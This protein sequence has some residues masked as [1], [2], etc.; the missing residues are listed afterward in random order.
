MLRS[1]RLNHR[2]D[3]AP[4]RARADE[5][6]VHVQRVAVF[7]ARAAGAQRPSG[8]IEVAR[9]GCAVEGNARYAAIERPEHRGVFRCVGRVQSVQGIANDRI[10]IERLRDTAPDARIACNGVPGFKRKKELSVHR[11]YLQMN[12]GRMHRLPRLLPYD[13]GN[14]DFVRAQRDEPCAVVR[15]D[16]YDE[17]P[18]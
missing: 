12:A 2:R 14:I 7:G 6:D 9:R 4:M 10:A 11:R 17:R 16:L 13:V 8:R 15:I 5:R 1:L 3:P 18:Q